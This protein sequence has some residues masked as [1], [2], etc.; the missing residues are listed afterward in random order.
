VALTRRDFCQQTLKAASLLGGAVA[1]DGR[2]LGSESSERD[3]SV[4]AHG[5]ASGDPLADRVVLWTRV[6]DPETGPVDAAASSIIPLRYVVARDTAF[7]SI[8]AEGQGETSADRDF[9]YQVDVTCLEPNSSYYYRFEALGALSP[10]GRTRTLPS[11]RVERFRL[12]FCSCSNYP[13]GY[14]NAYAKLAAR[15]ELDVVLHLGDYIY[16]YENG[17]YVDG[18]AIG[19][20]SEPDHEIQSLDDYRTRYAQY[21]RDP[22]LQALHGAHPMIVVWDDHEFADGTSLTGANN[23]QADEGDFQARRAA[24]RQ[25]HREWLPLRLPEPD[26]DAR[27]YRRFQV[28]D[29]VDLF[30]LDT[31]FV[32]RDPQVEALD[33]EALEDP[34]RSL[35]GEAQRDWLH[36]GLQESR[37]TWRL[38]GQQ[39]V[40][41]QLVIPPL[42]DNPEQIA[43]PD[44]WDGYPVERRALL[45]LIRDENIENVVVLTGDIHSAWANR[46]ALDPFVENEDEASEAE[47]EAAR[48]LAI[49]LVTPAVS[50]PPGAVTL[51]GGGINVS[52][53]KTLLEAT[54]P[55]VEYVELS[56][57]GYV[58]VEVTPERL[59]ADFWFVETTREP[60]LAEER[61]ASFEVESGV[62]E[63]R[64]ID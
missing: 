30:M 11:G 41:A 53:I 61:A 10:V 16:E 63:L 35:L 50:S 26:D 12:G 40:M 57:N 51:T 34:E 31:R 18:A 3:R 56:H 23:H 28:G 64:A 58:T 2:S 37:A 52:F 44:Q 19:R 42:G 46:I 9:T 62:A 32:G 55:H 48:P 20:P 36:R 25:A 1:C 49:E 5:V 60:N 8:V 27:I 47:L 39:V 6:S 4:F 7:E 17:D 59:R 54:H 14:F 15:D 24:A 43:N 38:L 33:L 29:L 22:D 21:R 45:E 13:G